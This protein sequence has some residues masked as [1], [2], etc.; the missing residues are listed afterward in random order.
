MADAP[1]SPN[2]LGDAAATEDQVGL[3]AAAIGAGLAASVA[4]LSLVTWLT[5]RLAM[6]SGIDSVEALAPN[7]A[8]VNVI[9]YG[10]VG[11]MLV[12]G[13]FAW[14]LMR[15][16]ESTYRRFG[17]SMVAVLGGF[18]VGAVA[19]ALVRE[20]VGVPFLPTLGGAALVLA[21][22]G[23]RRARRLGAPQGA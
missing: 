16:I 14:W 21:L 5:F 20:T 2:P 17:L 4:V 23:A 9:T 13:L 12:T 11:T 10:T 22:L 8:Q 6:A 7:A 1:I 18:V 19:T 15:P 3:A